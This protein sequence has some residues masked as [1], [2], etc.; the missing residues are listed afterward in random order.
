MDIDSLLFRY[1]H[2]LLQGNPSLS[3]YDDWTV[4]R[5][6]DDRLLG[7]IPE[8]AAQGFDLLF[9]TLKDCGIIDDKLPLRPISIG[10]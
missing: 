10:L 1:I 5:T 3:T 7:R 2:H 8:Q 4:I 6:I 9:D